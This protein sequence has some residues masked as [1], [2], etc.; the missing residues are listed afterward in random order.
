MVSRT[1]SGAKISGNESRL[2]PLKS[3]AAY[4][5]VLSVV[6][7]PTKKDLRSVIILLSEET[8]FFDRLMGG[9][10]AISLFTN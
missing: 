10:N 2:V 3:C 1:S 9:G 4:G 6:F 8:N 5:K 7:F